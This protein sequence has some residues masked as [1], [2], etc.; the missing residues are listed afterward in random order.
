[1]SVPTLDPALQ[2][3]LRGALALVLLLAARHKWADL[4]AFRAAVAG[5]ALLPGPAVAPLAA[6]F[7]AAELA[8]AAGLLLPATAP[9]AAV[10]AALL[11]TLYAGAIGANLLR[12][13][14]SIDCGCFGPGAR[15][16]LRPALLLRNA[17]LVLAALLAALPSAPRPLVWIDSLTVAGGAAVLALLH[18]AIEGA[19]ANGPRLRMGRSGA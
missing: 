6:G 5:Y 16:P 12:G 11:L 13:R 2:A 15:R 19:L 4:A 14:R 1:M 3:A 9:P 17:V 8:L 18:A 7:A 10:G